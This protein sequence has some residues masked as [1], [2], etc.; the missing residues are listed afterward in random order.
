LFAGRHEP[1]TEQ[2]L[3]IQEYLAKG[4]KSLPLL[5]RNTCAQVVE[6]DR[7]IRVATIRKTWLLETLD[8]EGIYRDGNQYSIESISTSGVGVEFVE[9]EHPR[10]DKELLRKKISQELG[11]ECQ[12]VKGPDWAEDELY[13]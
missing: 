8:G 5:V 4:Q 13:G 9:D 12:W 10:D 11:V 3:A 6:I 2:V 1:T 7:E